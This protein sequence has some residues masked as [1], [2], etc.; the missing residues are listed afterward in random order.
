MFNFKDYDHV[1]IA[2]HDLEDAKKKF[3]A[4]FDAKYIKEVV[5]EGLAVKAAYYLLGETLVGL[6]TPVGDGDMKRYLEKRGEGI[7][8]VALSVTNL[9]ETAEELRKKGL[10]LIG[11]EVTEGVKTEVFVH[12]KSFFNILLQVMEWEEPYRSS[13]EKRIEYSTS[14]DH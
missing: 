14:G 13:L 4:M 12:P 2:V 9:K 1:A 10:K 11:P 6:E 7:H 8:H 5:M 3:E